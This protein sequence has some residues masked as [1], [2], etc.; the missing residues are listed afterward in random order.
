[1][2]FTEKLMRDRETQI[3]AIIVFFVLAFRRIFGSN[4][5]DSSVLNTV[6]EYVIR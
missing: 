6:N 4:N 2:S 1:M 3:M 5:A